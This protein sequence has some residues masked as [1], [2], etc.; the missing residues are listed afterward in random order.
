[1]NVSTEISDEEYCL[2]CLFRETNDEYVKL[3]TRTQNKVEWFSI[4]GD[5]Y[6]EFLGY[7]EDHVSTSVDTMNYYIRT[8]CE[9]IY[10]EY[11][12]SSDNIDFDI[13]DLYDGKLQINTV[14]KQAII[15]TYKLRSVCI[16][17]YPCHNEGM[18]FHEYEDYLKKY[19]DILKNII[20]I[21]DEYKEC[22]NELK[23][24]VDI[25]KRE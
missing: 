10:K 14:I 11:T 22:I 25:Q 4:P 2:S 1:M 15:F 24:E 21:I 8:L 5:E 17:P 19:A 18:K 13:S 23:I 20:D 7:V 16:F 12:E 6:H 3:V 9:E